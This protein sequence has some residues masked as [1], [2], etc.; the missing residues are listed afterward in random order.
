M[1]EKGPQV[2]PHPHH[3]WSLG[4]K[5]PT[6]TITMADLLVQNTFKYLLQLA[7][8]RPFPC[9]LPPLDGL[10][11]LCVQVWD[12]NFSTYKFFLSLLGSEFIQTLL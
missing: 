9:Q 7:L 6:T 5:H 10:L 4:A 12:G 2:S 1:E 11:L 8:G 3:G